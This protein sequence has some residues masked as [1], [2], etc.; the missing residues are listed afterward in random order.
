MF[1]LVIML[2]CGCGHVVEGQDRQYYY[3]GDGWYH[4]HKTPEEI[5][6]DYYDCH[7]I[8]LTAPITYN[9]ITVES[10]CMSR[11]GYLWGGPH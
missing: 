9:P 10:H 3:A 1:L 4:P 7:K 6:H 11:R 5:D 8:G 2:L